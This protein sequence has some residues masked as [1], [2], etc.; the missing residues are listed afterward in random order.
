MA[1]FKCSIFYHN[2]AIRSQMLLG[3]GALSVIL[4]CLMTGYGF[5]FVLA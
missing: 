4:C 1:A 5:V 2:S 3:F